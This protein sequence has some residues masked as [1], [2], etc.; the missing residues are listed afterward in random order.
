VKILIVGAWAWQQY[1]EAFA[2]G[3]RENGSSVTA[4]SV[5]TFFNGYLGRIQQIIPLPGIALIRLNR[6]VIDAAK[7]QQPD[8][9]LFWR[10][11]HILPKTIRQLASMGVRTASYNNDDPFGPMAHGNVFWHHHFLW[12]W[13]INCLPM[14]NYNFFYRIV[15]CAEA[16]AFGANH[17]KV[18]LPYFMPWQ[19]HP[20]QLNDAEQKRF[21]TDVTFVGHYEKDGRGKSIRALMDAG[22]QIKIWSG[23]YW[24]RKILGDQFDRLSPIVPALGYEYGKA[25][26]G[27]KICLCFLSK[28]NRDT[29][30]RRCFEIP[31]CGR[32]MLAERTTDL[33]RMFKE[34]QEACFFSS[35]EELVEKTRWLLD[36]PTIRDRIAK[37]GQL[38]VWADGHDVGSRAK[39]FLSYI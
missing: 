22:I 4:L 3:L 29:Y 30:T 8:L 20:V 27:A 18:L 23:N 36:N 9:I 33:M 17:A 1:E 26:C 39:Q 2:R 15:N 38:R 6:A 16:K 35:N 10:P 34:N 19:D 32:L 14:F 5:T 21:A 31:A 13:Y 37:A 25:L 11:T 24:T 12:R 28:L 7:E